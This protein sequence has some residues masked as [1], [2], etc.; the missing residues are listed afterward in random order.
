MTGGASGVHLTGAL[1]KGVRIDEQN[2]VLVN[3]YNANTEKDQLNTINELSEM[4][5]SAN[6]VSA[7]QIILGGD[8][9]LHFDSLIESQGR[10]PI[11]KKIYCQ[12]D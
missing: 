9:N 4:L 2:F 1:G 10:N 12:N 11:F 3:L 8:F 5:K 6:N 7:K